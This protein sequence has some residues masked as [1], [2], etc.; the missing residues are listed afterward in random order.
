MHPVI[1]YIFMEMMSV[2]YNDVG[3][4]YISTHVYVHTPTHIFTHI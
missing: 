2:T 1:P 4:K 3:E